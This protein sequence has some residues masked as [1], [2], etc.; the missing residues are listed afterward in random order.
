LHVKLPPNFSAK[1]VE[2][3]I[4]ALE[5]KHLPQKR[6]TEDDALMIHAQLMDEYS[7]A[8]EKLAQ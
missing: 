5:K 3:I 1:E 2:V 4:L 7:E 8:F 6:I